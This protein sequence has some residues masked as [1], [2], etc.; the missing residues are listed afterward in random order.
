MQNVVKTTTCEHKL[1]PK[2]S[3]P[4]PIVPAKQSRTLPPKVKKVRNAKALNCKEGDCGAF[5][6][7]GLLRKR[8][9]EQQTPAVQTMINTHSVNVK[10]I[11]KCDTGKYLLQTDH[12][13]TK[14]CVC[15][16]DMNA[17]YNMK[18]ASKALLTENSLEQMRLSNKE[19]VRAVY[20]SLKGLLNDPIEI[21]YTERKR[22]ASSLLDTN[23]DSI[24]IFPL[25][26][27]EGNVVTIHS[28]DDEV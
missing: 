13:N 2:L 14:H 25:V 11:S 1:L 7:S 16:T 19:E 27:S 18:S 12:F 26:H 5:K 24:D 9:I 28:S 10:I 20:H 21:N 23:N 8:A 22:K 4:M 15:T 17:K 6:L 3:V